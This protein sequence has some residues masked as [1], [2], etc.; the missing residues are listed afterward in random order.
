[1]LINNTMDLDITK[2]KKSHSEIYPMIDELV[3]SLYTTEI[4]N[5][6]DSKCE[7]VDDKR[8]FLMFIIIY[9]YTYLSVPK[10]V[11]DTFNMK[12]E[13]KVFMTDVIRNP[14]KRSKMVELYR[15][16]ENSVQLL[17]N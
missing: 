11:K 7:T 12:E 5:L 17:K 4:N 2:L 3:D 9:F 14:E 6:I 8:V 15:N 16:F 13:L 1:M 10:D